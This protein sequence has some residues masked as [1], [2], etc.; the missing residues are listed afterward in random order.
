MTGLLLLL[1]AALLL[2]AERRSRRLLRYCRLQPRTL[3][4]L[5]G[6]ACALVALGLLLFSSSKVPQGETR[7]ADLAIAIAVDVSASMTATDLLPSRLDRARAEIAALL[8]ALPGARFALLPFAG[9]AVLQ[10]PL[11]SDT[12]A[13]GFFLSGLDSSTVSAPG[14]APQEALLAARQALADAGG[15]RA[16]VLFSDFERTHPEPPPPLPRDLPVYLVPLATTTGATVP[17]HSLRG[18][19]ATS[20]LDRP[21]LVEFARDCAA[22]IVELPGTGLAA[23]GLAARLRPLGS[24]PGS[25]PPVPWLVLAL[26]LLLA[27]QLP[28]LP[29]WRPQAA[30]G[31]LALL[32][33]AACSPAQEEPPGRDDFSRGV[34]AAAARDYPG[35]AAAFAAAA[36]SLEG[37]ERGIAL[38]NS[39]SALLQGGQAPAALPLLEEALLL[40]PGDAEVRR[41]FALALREAGDQAGA[42][43]GEEMP[44][45]PDHGA[46]GFS[47]EQALQLLEAVRPAPGAP[48][49]ATGRVF[50]RR[51]EKDW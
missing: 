21:G 1:I 3:P 50:E 2:L 40:L 33:F 44:S 32:V 15:V 14:S 25:A 20:R 19:P 27:R 30:A 24:S 7:T 8:T 28:G 38:Y 51:P 13:L 39:G 46:D 34:S 12:R 36:A 45:R 18:K 26:A 37:E 29:G 49:T 10:V 35:A 41:N 17:G 16:I 42:G 23:E 11:T 22:S 43:V 9:E 5:A 47:A 4:R 31:L 6:D 48:P